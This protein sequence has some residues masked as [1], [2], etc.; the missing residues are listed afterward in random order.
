MRAYVTGVHVDEHLDPLRAGRARLLRP[1]APRRAARRTRSSPDPIL[2]PTTKA[3]KGEH[4][5]SGSRE[6][7]LATGKV[8]RE[9]LRRGGRDRARLFAAR[10]DDVR[11]ARAHPRRHQVRARARPGTASVVVIDE[12]HTPD[13]SRFWMQDTYAERFATGEDPEPLDKD[14][15]RRHYTKQG[16]RG[17]GPPPRSPTTSASA[18]P[19]ATSRPSSASRARASSRTPSRRIP[20]IARNLGPRGAAMKATVLVRLKA[21]V[22]DPQGDAVAR[23]SAR[24][25]SR[26]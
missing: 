15:V 22:L 4:D 17:D 16:Y 7:I 14:F 3:P 20:R 6:E 25:G 19:S 1:Q 12:I 9:G 11:R 21:E 5:V 8:T 26:G 23:R 18:P 13:S 10:A 24:S 2:T